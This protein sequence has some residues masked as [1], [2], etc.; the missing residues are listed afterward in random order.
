MV[1]DLGA[2][3]STC[4]CA[5]AKHGDASAE[6]LLDDGSTHRVHAALLALGSSVL[7]DAIQ[8][9]SKQPGQKRLR[10]PLPSTTGDQAQALIQLLYSSRRETY[11]AALP[12]EQLCLLSTICHRFSF[13]DLLGLVDQTMAEH[14]GDSCPV[15]LQGQPKLEQYLKP[16]NA[17]AMYWDARAKGLDRFQMAC[18]RFI[19]SARFIGMHIKEVAEAAPE[20]ALGPVIV[21]AVAYAGVGILGELKA[22]LEQACSQC[23]ILGYDS[24]YVG[25]NW[26]SS[27]HQVLLS[28]MYNK[29]QHLE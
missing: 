3:I 19:G 1:E 4:C 23:G 7:G 27:S 10:I 20:D 12:L 28:K 18:A 16:E 9:D 21:Q 2:E 17:A 6:V 15:E 26:G 11:A 22:D 24:A 8:L 29:V 25:W 14:S 13:E 5:Q